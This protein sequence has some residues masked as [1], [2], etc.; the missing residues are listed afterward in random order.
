MF[1]E[2][3]EPPHV[4]RPVSP[5]TAALVPIISAGTPS[6]T[7]I[8]HDAPSPSHSLSSSELQPLISHQGIVAGSTSIKDNPF[9]HADDNPFVNVFALEPT[10]V[11]SSSRDASSGESTHVTQPHNHLG[12]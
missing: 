2:Y 10:S 5:A 6:T 12:K 9:A 11:A 4:E 8:D 3:L 7:T 1:D